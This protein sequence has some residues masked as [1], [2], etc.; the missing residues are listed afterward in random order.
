MA[1]DW[2]RAPGDRLLREADMDELFAELA[3]RS[4]DININCQRAVCTRPDGMIEVYPCTFTI[5]TL[6]QERPDADIIRGTPH[7]HSPTGR[8]GDWRR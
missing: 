1:G 2:P 3:A 7:G 5:I 6:R 8:L 4:S